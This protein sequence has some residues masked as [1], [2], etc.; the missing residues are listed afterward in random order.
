MKKL[1]F[2]MFFTTII[3]SLFISCAKNTKTELTVEQKT[4]IQNEVKDQYHKAL[5]A[6][7]QL[8]SASWFEFWS[9]DGFLTAFSGVNYFDNRSALVDT[10]ANW[11]SNRTSQKFEPTDI[12]VTPLTSELALLTSKM[13]YLILFKNESQYKFKGIHTFIWK[14]EQ[15]G[16]KIIH[17]HESYDVNN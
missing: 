16:W 14:K 8:N 17:M 1:V 13:D 10:V 9:K 6:I 7:N 4:A 11:F 5:S 15:T 12:R 2:Y 3:V